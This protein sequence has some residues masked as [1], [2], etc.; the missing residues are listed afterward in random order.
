MKN[1][2]KMWHEHTV[3]KMGWLIAYGLIAIPILMWLGMSPIKYR[4]ADAYS[5]L[6]STGQLT[7]L[8][9]IIFFCINMILATRLKIFERMFGGLNKVYIAHHMMGGIALTIILL[10]PLVLSLRLASSSI[11]D[12]AVILIPGLPNAATTYGIIGLWLF[13]VLMMLTFYFSLPYRIWLLTHKFLGLAFLFIALHVVLITSD[14]SANPYLK[15]YLLVLI[16]LASIAFVYRTL[17]PRFF[18]RRYKYQVVQAGPVAKGVVR[19]T[20]QP[21][22][23]AINF[24]PGQFVF[25]SFRAKGVSREWHPFSVSS[26]ANDDLSLTIKALG[27]YTDKL[28]KIAPDIIGQEVLVEGGYGRFSFRNFHSRR[29]IWVAGGIGITPFLSMLPEV[30]GDYQIDLFYSVKNA[31]ELMDIN[32]M[33]QLLANNGGNL[34]IFPVISDRDGMLTVDRIIETVGDV[35]DAEVLIC[36]PPPMMAALRKQ[37]VAKGIKKY[38]VHSE[39]FA[40][41]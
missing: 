7:G 15:W 13:I 16:I 22:Q 20:M 6:S 24:V 10:H 35:S 26:M 4:F 30:R 19:V 32:Y 17:M 25:V 8:V 31:S 27:T 1:I 28:T 18:V 41:S 40:M 37:F 39:E 34:R 29:Q 5:I 23:R 33:S 11:H 9:G 3:D 21:L 14:I 12:A 36:G 2:K 38:N